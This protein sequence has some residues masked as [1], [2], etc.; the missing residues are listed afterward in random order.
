[1]SE[2]MSGREKLRGTGKERK[3]EI[4][5]QSRKSFAKLFPSAHGEA[6]EKLSCLWRID[7]RDVRRV[8]GKMPFRRLLLSLGF[9]RRIKNMR[10]RTATVTQG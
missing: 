9:Q 3:R 4:V 5:S 10:F 2:R 6:G 1:M 7:K 8:K